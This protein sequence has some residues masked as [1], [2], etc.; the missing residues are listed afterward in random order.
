M[1]QVDAAVLKESQ[2]HGAPHFPYQEE[3]IND[4]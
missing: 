1:L 2:G 3:I 4:K